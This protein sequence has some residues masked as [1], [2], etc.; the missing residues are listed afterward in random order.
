MNSTYPF[1]SSAHVD[2]TLRGPDRVLF[3][4]IGGR[5]VAAVDDTR[6]LLDQST[7]AP[8]RAAAGRGVVTNG[9]HLRSTSGSLPVRTRESTYLLSPLPRR[10]RVRPMLRR[11]PGHRFRPPAS[12]QFVP[13]Q[14]GCQGA[15][16]TP[17]VGERS[18]A[19]QVSKARP[20]DTVLP[21]A[22]FVRPPEHP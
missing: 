22:R 9:L 21:L 11:T 5:L 3:R 15:L 19:R 7:G 14:Q 12:H 6:P 2:D 16:I 13:Y 4:R 20:G 10:T 17:D 1:C 8:V 18:P